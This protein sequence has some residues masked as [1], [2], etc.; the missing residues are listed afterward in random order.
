MTKIHATITQPY[1]PSCVDVER[2]PVTLGNHAPISQLFV[3]VRVR[4][5]FYSFYLE[6]GPVTLGNHAPISQLFVAVR[7]RVNFYSFYLER[8]PVTLGNHATIGLELYS[9]IPCFFQKARAFFKISC[10]FKSSSFFQNP[11]FLRYKKKKTK[12]Y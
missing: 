5:N 9:K 4:V 10:F 3:A 7:V 12:N 1:I 6:R 11:C 8:G 2:G